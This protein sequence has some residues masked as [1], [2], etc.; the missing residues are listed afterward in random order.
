MTIF[1]TLTQAANASEKS[2]F[3]KAVEVHRYKIIRP[4]TEDEVVFENETVE[5]IAG[6]IVTRI[7]TH[8]LAEAACGV[9]VSYDETVPRSRPGGRCQNPECARLLCAVH[10]VEETIRRCVVCHVRT[11]PACTRERDGKI[12]CAR[13]FEEA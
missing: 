7:V 12:F 6:E 4:G 13:H 9:L 8:I 3:T 10:A 1:E 2:D 5:E 11:C